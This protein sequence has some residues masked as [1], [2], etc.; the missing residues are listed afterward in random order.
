MEKQVDIMQEFT[1]CLR[2]DPDNAYDF[3]AQ[4]FYEFSKD[5][6]KDIVNELLYSLYSA[7]KRN[8]ILESDYAEIMSDAADELDDRWMN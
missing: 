2:S 6:L 3:I 4:R 8:D 1:E 5:E 7:K